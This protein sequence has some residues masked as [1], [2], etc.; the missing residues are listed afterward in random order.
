M[1]LLLLYCRDSTTRIF[2]VIVYR[3]SVIVAYVIWLRSVE[4][5][6]RLFLVRSVDQSLICSRAY[7]KA[8]HDCIGGNSFFGVSLLLWILS[9]PIKMF[10][11]IGKAHKHLLWWTNARAYFGLHAFIDR[12]LLLPS[13]SACPDADLSRRF[14]T[15]HVTT[16]AEY[17]VDIYLPFWTSM[18]F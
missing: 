10:V 18:R 12:P 16:T 1:K 6:L 8:F 13:S 11:Y 9:S 4:S 17:D 15:L 5:R 7:I 2:R 14:A 3:S